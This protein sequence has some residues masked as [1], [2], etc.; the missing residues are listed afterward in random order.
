MLPKRKAIEEG[1]Q[2]FHEEE[3]VNR[4]ER[5]A[6]EAQDLLDAADTDRFDHYEFSSL[7]T[8][9]EVLHL[10]LTGRIPPRPPAVG[11]DPYYDDLNPALDLDPE[12]DYW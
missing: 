5:V 4:A 8:F 3:L 1:L 11:S 2:D 12:S 6:Q 7:L 9:G 10:K